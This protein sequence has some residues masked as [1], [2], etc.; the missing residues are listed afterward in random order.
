MSERTPL[1]TSLVPAERL[2][3]Q[4]LMEAGYLWMEMGEPHKAREVFLGAAALLPKSE[5]PHLGLGTLESAQGR[6]EKA[7]QA[8]R[9]AQ[10]LAPRSALPRAHAGEALLFLGKERE[11]LKELQIAREVDPDGDG[12]KLASALMDAH[13]SGVFARRKTRKV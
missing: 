13:A 7:L 11:A 5:V 12:G 10:R 9:A 8:Y 3:A 4:I 1:E 6:H 2:H